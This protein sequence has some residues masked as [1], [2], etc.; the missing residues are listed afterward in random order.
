MVDLAML[1]QPNS[2][3]PWYHID[4]IAK[5][6]LEWNGN[7]PDVVDVVEDAEHLLNHNDMDN[8]NSENEMTYS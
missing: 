8:D 2:H 4:H 3:S 5:E 7:L 6:R 1:F